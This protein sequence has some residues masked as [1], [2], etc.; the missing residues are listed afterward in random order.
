MIH[1]SLYEL[2][3]ALHGAVTVTDAQVAVVDA[4]RVR[5]E[6]IDVLI[7]DAVFGG[8][9]VRAQ[10]KWLI[11][12]IGQQMGARPASIHDLYMARARGEYTNVTV[13]AM[14]LRMMSYDMMRA[15]LRAANQ[16]DAGA[17]IFE[18]ARSEMVF[19]MQEPD[20]YAA[21]V[22]AAA[23]REGYTGPLFIQGDHFQVSHK[24]YA[25]DPQAAIQEVKDLIT[26]AIPHG[27]WNIDIDTSTLVTLEPPDVNEQQRLNYQHSAELTDFVR[28]L[29]P[30]GVTISLGGEIGEVGLA[31]STVEELDAYMLNYRR[32]LAQYGD[33]TGLSKVSVA[34]GTTHGG[35]IMA[36]G[37]IG[38]VTVDFALLDTLGARTR[39]L[40]GGGAVQHGAS[41]LP[42]EV[43]HN[44]PKTQTLEIHL[45]AGFVNLV[46]DHPRF[47]ADLMQEIHAHLD[48]HHAH[49]RKAGDTITQ[50]YAKAR[51][52]AAGPF[53]AELWSLPADVY[54][55]IMHDLQEFFAFLF[56][57]LGAAN[58]K[59][60]V[61]RVVQPIEYHQ[62]R[63][64]FA[65][66]TAQS[67]GLAD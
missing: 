50:F 6:L 65:R 53:K 1:E 2:N 52:N 35:V 14:N 54:G 29:E 27:F 22:I 46:F 16:L 48:K 5:N 51:K 41:T 67:V 19:A 18:L 30:A 63:P 40:G 10:A 34:T 7:R 37:S 47:P 31:N 39:E 42:R 4:A 28:K 15:A 25:A 21:C 45:A 44:F 13:P 12:E 56:K 61:N 55:P 8:R 11:W 20:E 43:F 49:E 17:L 59:A 58:T 33:Y 24:K 62:S 60:L 36:D 32:A 38:D 9:D 26:R 3:V 66:K 23:I 64:V 57:E